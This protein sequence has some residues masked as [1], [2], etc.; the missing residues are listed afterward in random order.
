MSGVARSALPGRS[1]ALV[2][3]LLLAGLLGA[4]GG[5]AR[6]TP[7]ATSAGPPAGI[8]AP[9]GPS[10]ATAEARVVELTVRGGRVTGAT[11]R[12]EVPVGSEVV[13]RVTTDV[14]D[15]LHLHGYDEKVD[16]AAGQPGE[17]RFSADIPGT[18]EVE[19]EEAGTLLTRLLV[20]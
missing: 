6:P 16:L 12:V 2:A 15:E 3:A 17:L 9:P 8:T 7:A 19:L 5:G 20:R 18:F 4:C 1:R 10:S 13:L 14:A 11:G